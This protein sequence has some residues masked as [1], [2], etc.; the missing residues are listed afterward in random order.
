MNEMSKELMHYGILGMRWGVRRF[1]PYPSDYKGDGKEIGQAS[2]VKTRI[3]KSDDI[4]I[5]K[6]TKMYRLTKDKDDKTESKYLTVDP[7]DRTFYKATWGDAM[8]T[9]AGT[10]G[11]GEQLYENKYKNKEELKSPSFYKR[12]KIAADLTS[13]DSVINEMA[14]NKVTRMLME[15]NSG[16]DW[17]EM[18]RYAAIAGNEETYKK[19]MA[20]KDTPE[21]LKRLLNNLHDVHNYFKQGYKDEAASRDEQGKAKLLLSNMGGSD[22]IKMAYGKKVIEAGYNM[23]IDDHG[24]DFERGRGIVNAPIIVYNANQILKQ[25]GSKKVSELDEK[26]ALED[27]KKFY[28]SSSPKKEYKYH[29]PNVLKEAW[30]LGDFYG[31]YGR[32]LDAE[33]QVAK[34]AYELMDYVEKQNAGGAK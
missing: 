22:A 20:D 23:S 9:T 30:G 29:V 8:R 1:Q 4:V 13:D 14:V 32:K 17:K 2:R 12:Q 19:T 33:K 25:V 18:R 16:S 27:F 11:K 3:S 28:R 31:G 6:G 10:L 7:E 5:K 34:R 15:Q 24:A 26:K 21:S